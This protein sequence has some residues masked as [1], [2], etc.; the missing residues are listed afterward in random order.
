MRRRYYAGGERLGV[1]I[2]R[3]GG[4]ASDAARA[5]TNERRRIVGFAERQQRANV[6]GF[7]GPL[8]IGARS[9][10]VA[11]RERDEALRT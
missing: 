11:L 4:F 2:S 8:Q 6:S 5:H 1:V 3:N 10:D 7:N 9:H